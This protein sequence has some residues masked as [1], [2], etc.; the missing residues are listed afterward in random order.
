MTK[1]QSS[2]LRRAFFLLGIG[3]V[4]LAFFLN[5]RGRELTGIDAFTWVSITL[6]YLVFFI[7][8]FFLS[9]RPS[10]FSGKIP[11]LVMLW[12]GVIFYIV[13]SIVVIMLLSL[14]IS[15][16]MAIISQVVLLFLLAVN[17]YFALFASS[18]ARR[19]SVEEGAK[20]QLISEIKSKALFLVLSAD[21][22]PA[23]S[24]SVREIIKQAT[25]DIKYISPLNDGA[26]DELELKIIIS[27]NT[28][29]ELCNSAAGGG[30]PIALPAEV[31]KLQALVRE[32]KL[33]KN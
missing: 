20:Q 4:A 22:L 10:R 14:Y 8:F 29:M 1:N 6:M 31:K 9:I 21:S 15:M 24:G 2:L 30:H 19:V 17:G 3:V 28:L 12:T 13:A 25:E 32:R 16:N 5:T 18:Y 26:G 33:L 23:E 27:L 7:P 11:L